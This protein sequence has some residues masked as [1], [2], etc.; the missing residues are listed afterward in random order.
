MGA[1]DGRPKEGPNPEIERLMQ[2]LTKE[3][4]EL[5]QS[6]ITLKAKLFKVMRGGNPKDLETKPE[7]IEETLLGR[8]LR[9][10]IAKTQKSRDI[11][12]DLIDRV[13]LSP[14][15]S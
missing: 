10:E 3:N 14:E 11:I 4:D 15:E 8:W 12:N 7:V 1:D 5:R 9:E 6:A 2:E 13:E